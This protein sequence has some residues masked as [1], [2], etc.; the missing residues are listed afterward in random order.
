MEL[1]QA[2]QAGAVNSMDGRGLAVRPKGH[3]TSHFASFDLDWTPEAYL[4]EYYT[5]VQ[6]TSR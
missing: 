3:V 6:Q 4:A 2:V 1:V 5:E